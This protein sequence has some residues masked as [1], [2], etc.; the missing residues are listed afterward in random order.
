MWTFFF[1]PLLQSLWPFG[2]AQAQAA[3]SHHSRP[4]N[5]PIKMQ[6]P[7]IKNTLYSRYATANRWIAFECTQNWPLSLI[8]T[9]CR[10]L[11]GIAECVI[12]TNQLLVVLYSSAKYLKQINNLRTLNLFH[13]ISTFLINSIPN[14]FQ[15]PFL[16]FF[17]ILLFPLPSC[18]YSHIIK[19]QNKLL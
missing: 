5:N 17:R 11:K 3:L 13:L 9:W 14:S 15:I 1:L 10:E 2:T 7:F 8:S 12:L 16:S 6:F 18:C 19:M 4:S